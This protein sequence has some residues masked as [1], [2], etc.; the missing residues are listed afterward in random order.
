VFGSAA[1]T[2]DIAQYERDSN[3][4]QRAG[5]TKQFIT[6]KNDRFVIGQG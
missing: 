1:S 4:S 2:I 3:G 6:L 5:N